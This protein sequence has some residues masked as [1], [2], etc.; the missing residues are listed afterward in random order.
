MLKIN[1]YLFLLLFVKQE[2]EKAQVKSII[3]EN[4]AIIVYACSFF[5]IVKI[6]KYLVWFI[7]QIKQTIFQFLYFYQEM[8][9][10]LLYL[11]S[12][13]YKNLYSTKI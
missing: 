8:K 5:A 13:T 2:I 12:K 11:N 7:V 9:N 1:Q 4:E 10:S 3:V 6:Y